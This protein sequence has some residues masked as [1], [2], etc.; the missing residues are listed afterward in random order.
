MILWHWHGS[1]R[2]ASPFLLS[3]NNHDYRVYNHQWVNFYP[4]LTHLY[5]FLSTVY[6]LVSFSP[7]FSKLVVSSPQPFIL[8]ARNTSI[9]S[10]PPH[11]TLRIQIFDN[12]ISCFNNFVLWVVMFKRAHKS[13]YIFS[14]DPPLFWNQD[15][16]YN[17]NFKF[18][19]PS[20]SLFLSI[21]R[22]LF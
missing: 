8:H 15:L 14:I 22:I 4:P 7:P 17:L 20:T 18:P 3:Q 11:S 1:F 2:Q 13:C 9:F 5:S 6:P 10:S 12:P 19:T 21:V 16:K